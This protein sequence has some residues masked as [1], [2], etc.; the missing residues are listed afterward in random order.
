MIGFLW[1]VKDFK[2][3]CLIWVPFEYTLKAK[4]CPFW[5]MLDWRKAKLAF[6][7]HKNC[8]EKCQSILESSRAIDGPLYSVIYS[9][10]NFLKIFFDSHWAILKIWVFTN[11]NIYYLITVHHPKL[12]YITKRQSFPMPNIMLAREWMKIFTLSEHSTLLQHLSFHPVIIV[13]LSSYV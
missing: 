12:D 2:T 1:L 3:S 6:F 7:H 13:F 10:C 9:Y 5:L 8:F 4:Y 11:P